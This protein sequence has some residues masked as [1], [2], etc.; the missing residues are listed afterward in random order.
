MCPLYKNMCISPI[1]P[2]VFGENINI[3]FI[4]S[5]VVKKENDDSQEVLSGPYRSIID[6]LCKDIRI[7]YALTF[8]TKC[9]SNKAY[10][11]KETTECA[12]W[13]DL[14]I[15][16]IRPQLIIAFGKRIEKHKEILNKDIIYLD[17]IKVILDSSKRTDKLKKLIIEKIK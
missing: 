8:F 5:D 9:L 10:N 4:V 15:K 13:I 14:V 12:K 7:N 6:K 2:E 11:K 1:A 17:S 16:S 3:L